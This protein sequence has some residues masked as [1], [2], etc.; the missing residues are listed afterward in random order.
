VFGRRTPCLITV[1]GRIDIE[2]ADERWRK[3]PA[4]EA[5]RIC[6]HLVQEGLDRDRLSTA[7][8]APFKMKWI[9]HPPIF[10]ARGEATAQNR[11]G[12]PVTDR[13]FCSIGWSSGSGDSC[14]AGIP[15]A[16]RHAGEPL[17]SLRVGSRMLRPNPSNLLVHSRGRTHL[18]SLDS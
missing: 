2:T 7:T 9:D 11:A 15:R 3:D 6:K 14:G 13:F 17:R 4:T 12:M 16:V 18:P 1:I 5:A 10:V 8:F